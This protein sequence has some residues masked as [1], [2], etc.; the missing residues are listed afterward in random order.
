MEEVQLAC[1]HHHCSGELRQLAGL[2][3]ASNPLSSPPPSVVQ[4]GT[5]SV[6]H[7]LREQLARRE[8]ER[9]CERGREGER[10]EGDEG[11]GSF[12]SGKYIIVTCT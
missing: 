6:L 4:R 8:R 11:E 10:R 1:S 12:K 2:S 9:G 5:S 7:Y 3:L